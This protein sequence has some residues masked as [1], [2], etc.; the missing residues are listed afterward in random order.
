M[1]CRYATIAAL[2]D[3]SGAF[4]SAAPTLLEPSS[5]GSTRIP[6]STKARLA[7]LFMFSSFGVSP[8]CR[9]L[10]WGAF[11]NFCG[12]RRARPCGFQTAPLYG[13]SDIDSALRRLPAKTPDGD[14][15][16]G[17]APGRDH[18]DVAPA[19]PELVAVQHHVPRE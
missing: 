8:A 11:V 16:P 17:G 13:E 9:G 4:G 12:E 1:D 14:D 6:T 5:S 19:V 3:R 7:R 10:P 2:V 18:A 15:R